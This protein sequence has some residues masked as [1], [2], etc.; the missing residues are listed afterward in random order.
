MQHM[1]GKVRQ[2]VKKDCKTCNSHGICLAEV[3]TP[4]YI[5]TRDL[6]DPEQTHPDFRKELHK[7]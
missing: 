2:N 4:E 7:C 5:C 6:S 3:N 1:K